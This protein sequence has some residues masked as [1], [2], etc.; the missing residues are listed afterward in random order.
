MI[1]SRKFKFKQQTKRLNFGSYRL[2]WTVRFLTSEVN[3]QREGLFADWPGGSDKLSVTV[4]ESRPVGKRKSLYGTPCS[5][6]GESSLNLNWMEKMRHA[7]KNSLQSLSQRFST[8]RCCLTGNVLS[9]NAFVEP[10]RKCSECTL[11]FSYQHRCKSRA[12]IKSKL[13]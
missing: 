12:P 13:R 6:N 9:P 3:E 2:V 11:R 1:F 5:I 10:I 4:T 8:V 7:E